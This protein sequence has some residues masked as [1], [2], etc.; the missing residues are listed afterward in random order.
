MA[1]QPAGF[2]RALEGLEVQD[3]HRTPG[4]Q[5][6]GLKWPCPGSIDYLTLDEAVSAN[7]LEIT[8]KADG[9]QVSAINVVNRSDRPVFLMAGEL[10][11]GCKQDRMIN[12]SMMLRQK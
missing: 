9:P 10:L 11:I 2:L 12:A 3:L 8:E 4:L 6:F 7:S 5:V 1:S